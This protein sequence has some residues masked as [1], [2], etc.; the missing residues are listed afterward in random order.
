ME[1]AVH[2][3]QRIGIAI[4]PDVLSEKTFGLLQV[5][6]RQQRACP[7]R[8]AWLDV[9]TE[10]VNGAQFVTVQWVHHCAATRPQFDQTLRFQP[11][12]RL[13]DG[14]VADPQ[15]GAEI[16]DRELDPAA[17]VPLRTPRRISAVTRS[18][19][20]SGPATERSRLLGASTA[21]GLC[22]RLINNIV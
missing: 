21:V 3:P 10:A 14:Y 4:A 22:S 15:L 6:V 2:F 5:V 12:Q 8:N 20:D 9:L 18:T 17:S 19:A 13:A 16:R 11:A 7:G 1:L